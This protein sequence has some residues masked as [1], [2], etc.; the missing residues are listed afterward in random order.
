MRT[1]RKGAALLAPALLIAAGCSNDSSPFFPEDSQGQL[2]GPT[3]GLPITA[4]NAPLAAGLAYLS[5]VRS[6]QSSTFAATAG[7]GLGGGVG[8]TTGPSLGLGKIPSLVL[9]APFGPVVLACNTGS[10]SL[11]GDI[12]DPT[13]LSSGDTVR[14]DFQECFDTVSTVTGVVDATVDEY[15]PVSGLPDNFLLVML[16]TLTNVQVTIDGNAE[17][18]NGDAA[19]LIDTTGAPTTLSEEVAG[20]SMTFDVANRSETLTNYAATATFTFD[21]EVY[22]YTVNTTGTV[23]STAMEAPVTYTTPVA[24]QGVEG[25][26][27]GSGELLVAGNNSSVR[28]VAINNVNIRLDVDNNGDGEVDISIETTWFDLLN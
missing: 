6:S 12:S 5:A 20:N 24:L 27:P 10:V 8:K 16:M 14:M 22:Q 26:F 4:N 18:S 25:D 28:I 19:V 21:G 9:Q 3:A 17:T 13:G 15:T 23:S 7:A 11:S 2:Q 1:L